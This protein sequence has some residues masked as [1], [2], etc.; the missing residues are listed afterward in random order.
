[1]GWM[2]FRNTNY[3]PKG[4]HPILHWA[5][6]VKELAKSKKL[7]WSDFRI[8]DAMMTHGSLVDEDSSEG[9]RPLTK[10]KQMR[11]AM[12]AELIPNIYM[13]R[14]CGYLYEDEKGEPYLDI[15][16]GT[17]VAD[18]PEGWKCPDCGASSDCLEEI[19]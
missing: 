17:E 10:A 9:T 11:R 12:K 6:C 8:S 4:A 14:S 1:M 19:L 5:H 3:K 15:S 18:F 2:G 7:N 13:C 16:S